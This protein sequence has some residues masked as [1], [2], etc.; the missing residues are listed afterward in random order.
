MVSEMRCVIFLKDIT[1]FTLNRCFVE[2]NKQKTM[3]KKKK[4]EIK[5]KQTNKKIEQTNQAKNK[6]KQNHK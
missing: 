2:N 6:Q 3:Q 1:F 4:N 5:S